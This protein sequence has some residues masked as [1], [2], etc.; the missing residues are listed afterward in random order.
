MA[1]ALEDDGRDHEGG[2]EGPKLRDWRKKMS[3][4]VALALIVYTI[5]HIFATVEAMKDTGM[6]SLALL[7][8]AV[9]VIGIIPACRWFERRWVTLSDDQ[10]I[11]PELSGAF[12]RDQIMLWTLA[13]GLPFVLTA[14]FTAI[15]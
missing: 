2:H 1:R 15:A 4:N 10:A 3:D 5:L 6:K 9:L 14:F 7:A 12:R 8:L 11:N 13:I